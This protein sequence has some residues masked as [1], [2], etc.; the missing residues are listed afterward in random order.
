MKDMNVREPSVLEV[1]SVEGVQDVQLRVPLPLL[2]ARLEA[3]AAV[4]GKLI[5]KCINNIYFDD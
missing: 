1:A 4:L 5:L 3:P 2:Q